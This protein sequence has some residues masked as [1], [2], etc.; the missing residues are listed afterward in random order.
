MIIC[1]RP[2]TP[3]NSNK[4]ILW[5][6]SKWEYTIGLLYTYIRREFVFLWCTPLYIECFQYI[7]DKWSHYWLTSKIFDMVFAGGGRTIVLYAIEFHATDFS[8]EHMNNCSCIH[9]WLKLMLEHVNIWTLV[10]MW[11][12]WICEHMFMCGIWLWLYAI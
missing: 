3:Y 6:L 1:K 5:L 2:K 9:P 7:I 12:T 8:F 11:Y 10:H 4:S